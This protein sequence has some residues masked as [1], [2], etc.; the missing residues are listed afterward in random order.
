MKFFVESYGC[1]QNIAFGRGVEEELRGKG[2]FQADSS[3]EADLVIV[4]TCTVK[5]VTESR[6]LHRIA[7]LRSQRKE[8]LITGCMA[9]AQ[10]GTLLRF[11]N[12]DRIIPLESL[13]SWDMAPLANQKERSAE[14]SK[15]LPRISSTPIGGRAIL[16]ISR[17]CLGTCSYCIVKR[18]VGPLRSYRKEEI[19]SKAED[20]LGKGAHELYLTAQDCAVYGKDGKGDLLDLLVS[21]SDLKGNFR[22]RV[23]MM[24]PNRAI[25][26]IH[27]LV[28]LMS[29]SERFYRF[30]HLPV[31]SGDDT[32]LKLMNRSYAAADF[33]NLVKIGR[34]SIQD[35]NIT[36][37]LIVGFPYE[38]EEAF[39]N[40]IDLILETKPNKVNLSKFAAR[41][42][43]MASLLPSVSASIIDRRA[44]IAH[45][46]CKTVSTQLNSSLVGS[47]IEFYVLKE[48]TG[49][50]FG[51]TPNYLPAK[52]VS[53]R[54][55]E[56][57][58]TVIA[59]V[60]GASSSGLIMNLN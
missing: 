14:W 41:P 34:S 29:K 42:H 53:S 57:G 23:G 9:T 54:K 24:T 52:I 35:L 13:K 55:L 17:G 2:L 58:E 49:G 56:L 12:K 44:R 40:S 11:V 50:Y 10:P 51:R 47:E 27:E 5:R 33:K 48:V 38:T 25:P 60:T 21:L 32:I 37:D 8:L 4:N 45:V 28:G 30:L 46:A 16:P 18:A 7:S 43:T 19:V 59:K 36:T 22:I 3:D 39:Q 31:Q 20:S 1:A 15:R 26:M 6:M